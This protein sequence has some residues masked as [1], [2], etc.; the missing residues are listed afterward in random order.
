MKTNTKVL[1]IACV[2]IFC[3][4]LVFLNVD[5][6]FAKTDSISTYVAKEKT[7]SSVVPKTE[8]EQCLITAM[9]VQVDSSQNFTVF[10]HTTNSCGVKF[11]ETTRITTYLTDCPS[12]ASG[13]NYYSVSL[14]DRQTASISPAFTGGCVLCKDNK[15]VA[16]PPFHV[17]IT[18]Y[19]YGT[20]AGGKVQATSNSS[21]STISLSNNPHPY[22]PPC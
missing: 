10:E 7:P 11:T 22:E 17:R 1:R 15:P 12:Q 6:S 14:G 8:Y 9:Q 20:I 18:A 21:V 5:T 19:A 13:T 4:L 2:F 16:F 3:S